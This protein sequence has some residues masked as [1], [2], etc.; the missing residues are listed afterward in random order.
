MFNPALPVAVHK[1]RSRAWLIDSEGFTVCE[2]RPAPSQSAF[3]TARTLARLV[4]AARHVGKE[5]SHG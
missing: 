4:N 5:S 2:V 3:D 1:Y